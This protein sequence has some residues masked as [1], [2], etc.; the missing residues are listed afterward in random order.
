MRWEGLQLSARRG[1]LTLA[2]LVAL[3][4]ACTGDEDSATP[5]L[6]P[7]A[8]PTSSAA[9]E[10]SRTAAPSLDTATPT[11]SEAAE[12]GR[13]VPPGWISFSTGTFTAAHAP[14][15]VH[16]QRSAPEVFE[17]A[18]KLSFPDWM[19]AG[20]QDFLANLADATV[21]YVFL[22]ETPASAALISILLPCDAGPW[23]QPQLNAAYLA[24]A[25]GSGSPMEL[26]G[27]TRVSGNAVEIYEFS[28]LPGE[29]LLRAHIVDPGGCGFAVTLGRE[30]GTRRPQ[31]EFVQFLRTISF[32]PLPAP[33][34]PP[35]WVSYT[36]T[37]YS[38]ARSPS[39]DVGS[40]AVESLTDLL[41]E[42]DQ[43]ALSEEQ[44]LLISESISSAPPGTTMDFL[45]VTQS[46]S[47]SANVTVTS[48]C[49]PN[50][51]FSQRSWE[52]GNVEQGG[53]VFPVTLGDTVAA[54]HTQ[55]QLYGWSAGSVSLTS[56]FPVSASG[57]AFMFQLAENTGTPS[58]L[59]EFVTFLGTVRLD[60]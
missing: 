40:I 20:I 60:D 51:L 38:A 12:D 46:A 34:I 19:S 24:E 35:G 6:D 30:T 59:A 21:D 36:G 28:P 29:T 5:T 15:W 48:Q 56:V 8:I 49:T 42:L 9:R 39:W 43:F 57:C 25:A 44:R 37:R 55:L 1:Q 33:V 58:V 41:N 7:D 18:S 3:I 10:P 45:L 52:R 14:D 17:A 53:D 22:G 13:H 2:V 27:E 50:V 54:G 11:A 32:S 26:V 4:V 16:R 47:F 23:T 31:I